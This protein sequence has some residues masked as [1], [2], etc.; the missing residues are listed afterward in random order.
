MPSTDQ[1]AQT[2]SRAS[3][4]RAWSPEADLD[5]PDALPADRWAMS[6]ELLSLYDTPAWDQLSDEAARALSLWELVGFFSF[7]LHGERPLIQGMCDQLYVRQGPVVSD[8]LHHFIDEENKHMRM[9]ATFC[10]RYGGKVYGHKRLRLP[11][12][13]DP[14]E[15]QVR[16]FVEVLIVEELGLVYNAAMARDPR[17]PGIVQAINRIHQID[18]SRHLAMGHRL[19]AEAVDAARDVLP[20]T[21]WATL[22]GWVA[23]ALRYA[24]RDYVRPEAYADA[25]LPDPHGLVRLALSDPGRAR[26]RRAVSGRLVSRLLELDLL[27]HEPEL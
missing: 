16:F 27:Q 19:L 15:A 10:H 12:R 21:G 14:A 25:G 26:H 5:W 1:L 13:L 2:L 7:T 18:E 20:A 8:Y 9:F 11:R 4:A 22:Q 3:L 23:T 6:P 17:L 24:W